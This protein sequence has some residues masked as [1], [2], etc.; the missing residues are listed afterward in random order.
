MEDNIPQG[1]QQASQQD[2]IPKNLLDNFQALKDELEILFKN[3][4]RAE[5]EKKKTLDLSDQSKNLPSEIP[6]RPEE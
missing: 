4:E 5:A 2:N 3:L 1:T 6:Y